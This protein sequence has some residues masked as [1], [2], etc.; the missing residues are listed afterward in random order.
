M[1]ERSQKVYQQW[2]TDPF[3]DKATRQELAAI[4]DDPAEIEERF[5]QDLKFGTGGI[6][7]ILGAGTNRM[8]IYVIT[9]A[10]E[11]FARYLDTLGDEAKERGIAISY[12][13]RNG[14]TEFATRAAEAFAEHGYHVYLSDELRPTPMLSYMVRKLNCIGG[15]MVTASHNPAKYN[16]YKAYG[17]DGGQLPPEAADHVM[18]EIENIKDITKLT[19]MDLMKELRRASFKWSVLRLTRCITIISWD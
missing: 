9:Q 13:C 19:W 8:N 7:G 6:R 18:K 15:V 2:A 16:G 3:F 11:A 10:S 12:D 4:K 17:E 14:S 1:S 5:Y